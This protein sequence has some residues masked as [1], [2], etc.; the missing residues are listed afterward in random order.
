MKLKKNIKEEMKQAPK[1]DM[2]ATKKDSLLVIK[3][4]STGEAFLARA[5]K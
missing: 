5:G 1:S 4:A 3:E 2:M